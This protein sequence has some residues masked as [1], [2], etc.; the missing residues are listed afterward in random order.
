MIVVVEMAIVDAP[1][2]RC[3]IRL[4]RLR[5]QRRELGRVHR[6]HGGFGAADVDAGLA[7]HGLDVVTLQEQA[8]RVAVA[9]GRADLLLDGCVEQ[10]LRRH[11]LH[12]RR[13]SL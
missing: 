7:G 13:R 11:V 6:R 1:P 2:A 9:I 8:N 10:R 5:R 4:P 12:L 3:L